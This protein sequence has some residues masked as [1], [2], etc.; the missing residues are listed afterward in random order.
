MTDTI[1]TAQI[2]QA[3]KDAENQLRIVR[4]NLAPMVRLLAGNLRS[5]MAEPDYWDRQALAKI[6]RELQSFDSRAGCWKE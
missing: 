2:E 4:R 6:K 5:A 1:T 3:V